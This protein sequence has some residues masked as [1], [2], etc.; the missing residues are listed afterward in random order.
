MR[1]RG[2]GDDIEDDE[3]EY[4]DITPPRRTPEPETD[5]VHSPL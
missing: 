2:R 3:D 4:E 5:P 1:L